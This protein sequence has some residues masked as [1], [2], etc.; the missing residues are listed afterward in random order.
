MRLGLDLELL[1]AAQS[2]L[3]KKS[4]DQSKY[5]AIDYGNYILRIKNDFRYLTLLE[6]PS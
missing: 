4:R 5:V 1:L 3:V 2:S 6:K